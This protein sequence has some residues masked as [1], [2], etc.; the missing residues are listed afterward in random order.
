MLIQ[1]QAH[2]FPN[3]DGSDYQKVSAN[4]TSGLWSEWEKENYSIATSSFTGGV[5]EL[6]AK[7]PAEPD[8]MLSEVTATLPAENPLPYT[9]RSNRLD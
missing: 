1:K 3:S 8:S 6:I 5:T 7:A 9:T 2:K 4:D